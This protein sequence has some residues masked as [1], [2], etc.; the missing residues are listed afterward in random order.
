MKNIIKY[1]ALFIAV[2]G[3]VSSCG[4]EI[5]VQPGMDETLLYEKAGLVDSAV[6]YGC[7]AYSHRYLIE[8]TLQLTDFSGL[9]AEFD[10]HTSIDFSTITFLYNTIDSSN[11]EALAVSNSEL[12]GFH[13]F[14]FTK[15][16]DMM[17]F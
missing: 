6:V 2:L 15:S 17:W 4:N 12:N 7:Y 11:V 14:E 3:F 5:A 16:A 10:S 8:D 9:R 13:S 1:P